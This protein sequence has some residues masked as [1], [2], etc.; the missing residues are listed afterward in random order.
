M[1]LWLI[2]LSALGVGA[3]FVAGMLALGRSIRKGDRW[4]R[5]T[6]A[7]ALPLF[8]WIEFASLLR[9]GTWIETIEA[10]LAVG[11]TAAA[12]WYL[13]LSPVSRAYVRRNR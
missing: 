6:A 11:L 2:P 9:S 8:L 12:G 7:V 4:A 5:R 1:A 10:L 3:V 13:F